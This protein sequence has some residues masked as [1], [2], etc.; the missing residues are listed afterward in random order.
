MVPPFSRAGES[1]IVLTFRSQK[2][3]WVGEFP[4]GPAVRTWHFHCCGL[5]SIPGQGTRIPKAVLWWDQTNKQ[6]KK[7][8]KAKVGWDECGS[9]SPE[10]AAFGRLTER[11]RTMDGGAGTS[12]GARMA[13]PFLGMGISSCE[14][15]VLSP[16]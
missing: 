14:G 1:G 8:A 15:T 13:D 10:G 6:T 4:G 5:G 2:N 12:A 7:K 3:K 11:G 9:W 16:P